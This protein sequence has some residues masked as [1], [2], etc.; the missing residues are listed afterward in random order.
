[1]HRHRR[2]R[3]KLRRGV[4]CAD[5]MATSTS[6]AS[7]AHG[8]ALRQLTAERRRRRMVL[9]MPALLAMLLLLTAPR[10]ARA[11]CVCPQQPTCA[12]A[13][14]VPADVRFSSLSTC[15]SPTIRHS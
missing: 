1:V 14:L 11:R 13:D 6:A 2:R 10:S 9:A 15:R 8:A 7:P 3:P 4:R 5:T 12:L